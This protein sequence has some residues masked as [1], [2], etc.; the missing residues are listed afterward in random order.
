[1]APTGQ[2]YDLILPPF[3]VIAFDPGGTTGW[4]AV[5]SKGGN[6]AEMTMKDFEFG[7]GEFGPEEHHKD[8]FV[9][10][11]RAAEDCNAVGV[12][13]H[14]VSETFQYRQYATESTHRGNGA[15]KVSLISCEYIGIMK[16]FCACFGVPYTEYTPAEGKGYVSDIKLDKLGWLQLPLTPKRHIN[17]SARQLV[18]YLVKKLGIRHPITTL[19]R[20]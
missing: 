3:Q 12:E 9:F 4:S 17:D 18:S 16:A 7:C 15:A 11:G 5:A 13:L 1:L 10:L 8:L 14:I 6:A 2:K 19:W 20:D